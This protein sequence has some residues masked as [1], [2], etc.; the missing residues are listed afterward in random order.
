[1]ISL[2]GENN[3]RGFTLVEIMASVLILGTGLVLIINSYLIALKGLNSSGN[4]I[5][6]MR[7]AQEKMDSLELSVLK[8]GLVP[9]YPKETIDFNGKS[10]DYDLSVTEEISPAILAD[11]LAQSCLTLSWQE[12]NSTNNAI[13]PSY[14]P[15][16]KE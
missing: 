7:L 1:M 16:P 11:Y 3:S 9:Y 2:I 14:F 15:K 8:E 6:A 10:Y 5:Q 4:N 13:I 12:Q